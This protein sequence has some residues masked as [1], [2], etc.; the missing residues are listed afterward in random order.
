MGVP[1]VTGCSTVEELEMA[2]G[3]YEA[4]GEDD[5][6]VTIRAAI[7]TAGYADWS[8]ASPPEAKRTG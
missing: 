4:V 3:A 5:E 1:T 2:L 7:E 8:W 6:A